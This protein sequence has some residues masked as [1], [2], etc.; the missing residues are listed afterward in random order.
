MAHCI[1]ASS[2]FWATSTDLG[3]LVRQSAD[4][5]DPFE[6]DLELPTGD[7]ER[8]TEEPRI[9]ARIRCTRSEVDASVDE[10]VEQGDLV[11]CLFPSGFPAS[12]LEHAIVRNGFEVFS[13][14]DEDE[15]ASVGRRVGEVVRSEPRSYVCVGAGERAPI[16]GEVRRQVVRGQEGGPEDI[17]SATEENFV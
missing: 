4:C 5:L 15:V 3:R 6:G 2:L 1:T 7:A 13:E 10:A 17:L 8:D 14:V 11:V 12:L 9:R 16:L